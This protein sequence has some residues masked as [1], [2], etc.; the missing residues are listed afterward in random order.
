MVFG[1]QEDGQEEEAKGLTFGPP[2]YHGK[3]KGIIIIAR[4]H[5]QF[6]NDHE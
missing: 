4:F 5:I 1:G 3:E 6:M 2:M